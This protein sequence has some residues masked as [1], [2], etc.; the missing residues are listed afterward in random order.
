MTGKGQQHSSLEST[1]LWH[2]AN[3]HHCQF[4]IIQSTACPNSFILHSQL[5]SSTN[6]S[7]RVT[8][9]VVLSHH[10]GLSLKKGLKGARNSLNCYFP[11]YAEKAQR[12]GTKQ[13]TPVRRAEPWHAKDLPL[14]YGCA[15]HRGSWSTP[16][17]CHTT[18]APPWLLA[19]KGTGNLQRN[20]TNHPSF[21]W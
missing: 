18:T 3:L 13:L 9:G 4:S 17:L 19:G 16:D 20:S 10:K 5:S 11:R 14:L 12:D 15:V 21:D 8:C 2:G 1:V 7:R 6:Q